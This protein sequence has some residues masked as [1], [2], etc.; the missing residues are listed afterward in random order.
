MSEEIGEVA[1]P[2]PEAV[3]AE[4]I[5]ARAEEIA[6]GEVAAAEAIAE[7]AVAHIEHAEA[8]AQAVVADAEQ[9][10]EQSEENHRW[11]TIH[12]ELSLLREQNRQLQAM[13]ETQARMMETFSTPLLQLVQ[14]LQEEAEASRK[15][16][17]RRSAEPAGL[18]PSE[19]T[20]ESGGNA[21][22]RPEASVRRNK[23]R[24]I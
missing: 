13:L 17:P 1:A 22:Q 14:I 5:E 10:I 6:A 16:T 3:L 7:S 15:S 23:P 11:A 21:A 2:A 9:R 20:P 24:L 18:N 8:K 19:L 4:A 12:S